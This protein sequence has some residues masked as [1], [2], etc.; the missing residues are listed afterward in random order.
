MSIDF[1]QNTDHWVKC[2][3]GV[4][5]LP[6]KC[7][8]PRAFIGTNAETALLENAGRKNDASNRQ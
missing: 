7:A 6:I 5:Y 1:G 8:E 2:S 4:S 3:K